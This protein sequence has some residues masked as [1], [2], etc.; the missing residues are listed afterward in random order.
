MDH[1]TDLHRAGS[2]PP[3]EYLTLDEAVVHRLHMDGEIGW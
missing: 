3:P 2:P 1:L